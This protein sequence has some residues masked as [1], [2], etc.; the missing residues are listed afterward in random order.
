MASPTVDRL[1]GVCQIWDRRRREVHREIATIVQQDDDSD[2]PIIHGILSN[3][4]DQRQAAVMDEFKS[5]LMCAEMLIY[6]YRNRAEL[7]EQLICRYIDVSRKETPF[8]RFDWDSAFEGYRGET[9]EIVVF[10]CRYNLQLLR[11]RFWVQYTIYSSDESGLC[12]LESVRASS[13][14]RRTIN[15]LRITG[16]TT[17]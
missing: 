13:R 4:H 15:R 17:C 1:V 6:L 2:F 11:L 10:N 16:T 9:A 14:C 7:S 5:S 8:L 12:P 3:F